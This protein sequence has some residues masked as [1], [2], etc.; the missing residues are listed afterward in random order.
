MNISYCSSLLV[1]VVGV[2]QPP[3]WHYKQNY[4]LQLYTKTLGTV[5][6]EL[7]R[8]DHSQYYKSHHSTFNTRQANP[9]SNV[10]VRVQLEN[11]K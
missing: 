7:G 4:Q 1:V 5:R 3:L 9:F 11:Q 6:G 2:T 8:N 10:R